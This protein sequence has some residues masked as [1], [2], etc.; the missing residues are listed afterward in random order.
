MVL[1]G[2]VAAVPGC[3][4]PPAPSAPPVD[5]TPG[6]MPG[7]AAPVAL[8]EVAAAA[9]DGRIWVAGGLAA[10]GSAVDTVQVLD[11]AGGTWVGGPPLPQPVHHSALV[12]DGFRLWLVGGYGADGRPL[13]T[14]W[15]LDPG[16][17]TWTEHFPL[18]EPRAAGAATW[19]GQGQLVY[20]GGMGPAGVTADTWV[21]LEHGW[22]PY[23]RLPEP[24]EHLAA[25]SDGDG[26]AYV[27]GGRR[28][29]LDTNTARVTALAVEGGRSLGEVPT[30]RGGVAAFWWSG[31]GACLVGGESPG[32]T[33]AQVECIDADGT[34]RGLPDLARPR[35]GLGAVVLD[36]RAYA[37]LGGEQPGLFVSDAVEVLELP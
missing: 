3:A 17:D 35:H 34:V 13:A 25:T 36:G 29:G 12:N 28:G 26:T 18:P 16:A 7:P 11:P 8:T 37:L 10:D 22:E 9:F 21:Q 1:L 23:H 32:G 5:G 14:V 33:H 24:S 31:L 19:D 2:L 15:A 30:A 6:W 4:S 20:A 27:L